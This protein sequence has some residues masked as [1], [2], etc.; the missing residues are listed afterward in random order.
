MVCSK[1]L[2][3]V[4]V[5]AVTA[6]LSTPVSAQRRGP[7]GVNGLPVGGAFPPGHFGGRATSMQRPGFQAPSP[8]SLPNVNVPFAQRPAMTGIPGRQ[9]G[10]VQQFRAPGGSNQQTSSNAQSRREARERFR[11]GPY[12]TFRGLRTQGNFGGFSPNVMPFY[13][14]SPYGA[15]GGSNRPFGR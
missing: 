8:L 3:L 9:L 14:H 13:S 6:G 11:F 1:L 2:K 5:A 12:A 7:S 10:T 15:L 4:V